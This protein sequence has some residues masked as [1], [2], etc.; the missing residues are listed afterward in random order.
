MISKIIERELHKSLIYHITSALKLT[1]SDLDFGY[2]PYKLCGV[3]MGSRKALP[4]FKSLMT[5][6]PVEV[7]LQ[8]LEVSFQ[9]GYFDLSRQVQLLGQD[10]NWDLV[11]IKFIASYS[12]SNTKRGKYNRG[13]FRLFKSN[14]GFPL[15]GSRCQEL[16]RKLVD[17]GLKLQCLE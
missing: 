15:T 13:L 11:L 4:V 2:I 5:G 7:V 8:V 16:F 6:L 12:L 10:K 3:I 14:K 1:T 9:L 17:H